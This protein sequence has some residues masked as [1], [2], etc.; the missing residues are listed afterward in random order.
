MT[1]KHVGY[2]TG[3][4]RFGKGTL[5]TKFLMEPE[6]MEEV[7]TVTWFDDGLAKI[8]KL[9]EDLR[10]EVE[11]EWTTYQGKR[12]FKAYDVNPG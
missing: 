7:I 12:E 3:P 9:R 10:V 11:G 2:I 5:P 1:E 6:D 8:I 4:P